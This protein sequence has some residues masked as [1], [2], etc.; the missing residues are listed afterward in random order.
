MWFARSAS[1]VVVLAAV[2][3]ILSAVYLLSM[4]REIF[5]GPENK[6]LTSHEVL[7]DAEQM[8]G[9]IWTFWKLQNYW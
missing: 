7:V 5:F 8:T 1:L 9:I 6:E 4:L 2:G 3:V